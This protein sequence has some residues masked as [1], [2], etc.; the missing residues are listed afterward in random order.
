MV[1]LL[2]LFVGVVIT[3]V[4]GVIVFN[5]VLKSE[6][7]LDPTRPGTPIIPGVTDPVPTAVGIAPGAGAGTAPAAS[8]P[9]TSVRVNA[10]TSPAPLRPGQPAACAADRQAVQTAVTLF[11]ELQGRPPASQAELVAAGFLRAPSSLHDVRNGQ[12][13]GV[14]GCP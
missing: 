7:A 12:V 9:A 8:T 3:V 14:S 6:P 13:V 10:T 5:A 11:T 2:A 4:L 1:R